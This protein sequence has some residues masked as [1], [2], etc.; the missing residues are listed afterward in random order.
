MISSE[1]WKKI[2]RSNKIAICNLWSLKKFAS[3]Y[4]FQI[5]REE[6]K[7]AHYVQKNLFKTV[8]SVKTTAYDQ[9]NNVQWYFHIFKAR[10]S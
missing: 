4:L 9:N 1:I 8:R 10:K 3:A 2:S 7:R 5:A 6:A